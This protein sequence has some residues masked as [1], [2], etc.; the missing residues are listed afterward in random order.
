MTNREKQRWKRLKERP[1]V[2]AMALANRT[3]ILH[4]DKLLV[5]F[6]KD[7]IG[8]AKTWRACAQ[9]VYEDDIPKMHGFYLKDPGTHPQAE[10]HIR[11]ILDVPKSERSLYAPSY[12]WT[13]PVGASARIVILP[14]HLDII[15][16]D[17]QGDLR[18]RYE[19]VL[20]K[21]QLLA[22]KGVI[23]QGKYHGLSLPERL[24]KF[25]RPT[26]YEHNIILQGP[27][28][29]KLYEALKDRDKSGFADQGTI[30]FQRHTKYPR[31][32]A[33]SK[34]YD[35]AKREGLEGIMLHK[36]EVTFYKAQFK[37]H[38]IKIPDLLAQPDIQEL[39]HKD[40]VFQVKKAL[41]TLGREEREALKT[42][43]RLK[44]V[45]IDGIVK[46]LLIPRRTL[47]NC[48]D[49]LKR[50]A[51]NIELSMTERRKIE[52]YLEKL[53]AARAGKFTVPHVP[54]KPEATYVF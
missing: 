7:E 37:S 39:L 17:L 49:R 50:E 42:K 20:E 11:S 48:V 43:L 34:Y 51:A 47:T 44:S 3:I 4:D 29:A 35:I 40:L 2:D 9:K 26:E 27:L 45:N 36:L 14:N 18:P 5:R 23:I 38:G 32:M 1:A 15:M 30:Y 22:E 16:L 21:V 54:P 46:A 33:S 53:E 24:A 31:K 10:R 52:R 28:G 19:K 8:L 6:Q 41:R 13:V 12:E 25:G